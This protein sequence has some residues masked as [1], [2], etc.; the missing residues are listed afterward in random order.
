M[1]APLVPI[2]IVWKFTDCPRKDDQLLCLLMR[3][4]YETKEKIVLWTLTCADARR[5][6]KWYF[7]EQKDF[8][9]FEIRD[10]ALRLIIRRE[11]TPLGIQYHFEIGNWMERLTYAEMDEILHFTRL[12]LLDEIK[13]DHFK[14]CP[15]CGGKGYLNG[16]EN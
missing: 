3:D 15:T 12:R 16:K 7:Q 5:L 6:V 9:F 4:D 14:T 11:E 13:P 10:A 1:Y 2:R 8:P